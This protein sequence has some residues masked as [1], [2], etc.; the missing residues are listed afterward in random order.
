MI[1]YWNTTK[2]KNSIQKIQS[3]SIHDIKLVKVL[4]TKKFVNCSRRGKS[5]EFFIQFKQTPFDIYHV[6]TLSDDKHSLRQI[7]F[8]KPLE[9]LDR[10]NN[11]KRQQYLKLQRKYRQTKQSERLSNREKLRQQEE[12]EEMKDYEKENKIL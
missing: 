7:V 6:G 2:D 1:E 4:E 12:K 8:L 9:L 11:K 5:F 3:D 10:T